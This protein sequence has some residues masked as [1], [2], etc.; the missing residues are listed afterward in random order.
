[1]LFDG[2]QQYVACRIDGCFYARPFAVLF[3]TL[4]VLTV[5]AFGANAFGIRWRPGRL[6]ASGFEAAQPYG[7]VG[8]AGLKVLVRSVCVLA[9]FVAVGV[10]VWASMSLIAIGE[11]YE[12]LRSWHRA[13]ESAVG[14]LTG[15]QQIAL[16]VVAS[17]GV[18]VL[19]AAHASFAA[20]AARY[21]RRLDVWI[22]GWLVLL[23]GL[24][25]V[26][27]VANGYR[28]VGSVFLWEFLIDA[29]VWVT[30]WIDAPVI[31]LAT[32][33]VSWK[34]LA[35]RRLTM[36]AA[37]G[38]VL[39][40]AAFGLAWVTML[41]AAGVPLGDMPMPYPFW[42]L[43]PALLPLMATVLAPWSLSRIRHPEE[44]PWRRQSRTSSRS[45]ARCCWRF[46]GWRQQRLMRVGSSS[47]WSSVADARTF[48]C[49]A[50]DL[51]FPV[52]AR[53]AGD[54]PALDFCGLMY[55]MGAPCVRRPPMRYDS[56]MMPLAGS[57]F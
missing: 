37:S 22:A 2:F 10:S 20:L 14:A 48:Y 38:A 12:P 4:S 30:R 3:A 7:T 55:R 18:A 23:H 9:A 36:R 29:L 50:A 19:V 34:V 33:Y 49:L 39:I 41:R 11:G 8:L 44:N 24:L 32:V 27:L 54:V 21:P 35:E 15:Y 40:S 42:M 26:V 17:I 53:L 28:G 45:C 57:V 25:L 52:P 51:D 1:M 5:L 31:A 13:I 16:A 56:A 46:S 47:R 43:S 6:Y